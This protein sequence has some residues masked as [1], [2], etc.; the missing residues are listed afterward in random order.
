M[1]RNPY[2]I[3]FPILDT[4]KFIWRY[5]YYDRFIKKP[6]SL[7]NT[8]NTEKLTSDT[9]WQYWVPSYKNFS[10]ITPGRNTKTL[11]Y[12]IWEI[13]ITK[14]ASHTGFLYHHVAMG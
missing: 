3:L 4:F 1:G 13:N 6:K 9:K 10:H 11:K 14:A 12:V 8:M 2:M 7:T 5:K